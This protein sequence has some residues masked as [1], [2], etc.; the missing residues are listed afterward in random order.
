M[1]WHVLDPVEVMLNWIWIHCVLMVKKRILYGRS[2]NHLRVVLEPNLRNLGMPVGFLGQVITESFEFFVFFFLWANYP[3][4]LVLY[5]SL[6]LFLSGRAHVPQTDI[7]CHRFTL[8]P[9]LRWCPFM[10][11]ADLLQRSMSLSGAARHHGNS[12]SNYGLS[13]SFVTLF[14]GFISSDDSYEC[15][16]VCVADFFYH[17][18]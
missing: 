14:S 3:G 5:S 10:Y 2:M 13:F 6:Y 17:W 18:A 4:I 8:P 7:Y 9:D 11:S 16:W 12:G 1:C 15:V